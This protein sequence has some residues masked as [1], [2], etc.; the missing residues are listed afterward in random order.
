MRRKP[1]RA[2]RRQGLPFTARVQ[3]QVP[4][5]AEVRLWPQ[6]Q[7]RLRPQARAS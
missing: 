1:C 6:V 3:A 7:V 4:L 2:G 5:Q